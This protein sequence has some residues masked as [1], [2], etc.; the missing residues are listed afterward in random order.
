MGGVVTEGDPV[1][2]VIAAL[3][4]HGNSFLLPVDSMGSD[5]LLGKT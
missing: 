1:A 4:N 3:R 5:Q 2:I